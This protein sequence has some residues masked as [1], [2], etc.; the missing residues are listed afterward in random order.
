MTK[1]DLQLY[2]RTDLENAA[3]KGQV[4][5]WVQGAGGLLVLGVVLKFV[6]LVPL[7]VV[8]GVAA[9]LVVRALR[10]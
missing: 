7:L 3:T 5:G 1:T 6:G 9:F 2:T 8:G 4:I 10:K